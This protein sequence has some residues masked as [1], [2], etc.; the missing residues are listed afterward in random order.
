M[1]MLLYLWHGDSS[2]CWFSSLPFTNREELENFTFEAHRI[3]CIARSQL[4]LNRGGGGCLRNIQEWQAKLVGANGIER[5]VDKQCVSSNVIKG[6][7]MTGGAQIM[8]G[9]AELP[10]PQ[11]QCQQ[12]SHYLHLINSFVMKTQVKLKR[13][14]KAQLFA[15]CL[16]PCQPTSWLKDFGWLNIKPQKEQSPGK[17]GSNLGKIIRSYSHLLSSS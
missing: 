5:C 1:G 2:H 16:L 9:M 4:K 10:P 17:T 15:A 8:S 12:L 14:K 13:R 3:Q 6:S 11:P 7:H